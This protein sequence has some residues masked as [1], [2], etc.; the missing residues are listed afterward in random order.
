[1]VTIMYVFSLMSAPIQIVLFIIYLYYWYTMRNSRDITDYQINKKLFHIAIAMG[2]TIS[3]TK[4][5]FFVNWMIFIV[6]GKEDDNL[7]PLTEFIGSMYVCPLTA[8]YNRG[9]IKMGE[10]GV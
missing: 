10:A 5:F 2:A 8:L 6:R 4:L 9:I 7:N 1:M 3:F